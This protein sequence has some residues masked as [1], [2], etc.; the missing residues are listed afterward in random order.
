M[1]VAAHRGWVLPLHSQQQRSWVKG[2]L[3]PPSD[4]KGDDCRRAS[5]P[6]FDEDSRS[7][8]MGRWLWLTVMSYTLSR[9]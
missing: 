7:M 5:W 9:P 2:L 6:G 8:S 3:H 4:P 1:Q